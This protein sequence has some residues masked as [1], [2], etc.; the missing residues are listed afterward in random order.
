MKLHDNSLQIVVTS[1]VTMTSQSYYITN[2]SA[3]KAGQLYFL[4]TNTGYYC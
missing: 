4:Y 2:L 1:S 3:T